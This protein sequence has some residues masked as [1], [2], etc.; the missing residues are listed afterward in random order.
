M[1]NPMYRMK[2]GVNTL[3]SL[4]NTVLHRM[5]MKSDSKSVLQTLHGKHPVDHNFLN[6]NGESAIMLAA[7]KGNIQIVRFLLESGA[8]IFVIRANNPERY[9]KSL[10]NFLQGLLRERPHDPNFL[11]WYRIEKLVHI[12][13]TLVTS[14]VAEMDLI[15]LRKIEIAN[16][17]GTVDYRGGMDNV[18]SGDL[19]NY[20]KWALHTHD[21]I[22][23]HGI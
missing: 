23:R 6:F 21:S 11:N 3:D 10:S 17:L 19:V 8:N 2:P 9:S 18:R 20:I 4:G 1:Y 12:I 14:H 16:L 13:E 7:K 22:A 5:V 15:A